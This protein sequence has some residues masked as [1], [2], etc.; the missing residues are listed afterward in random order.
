MAIDLVN[1]H[2]RRRREK[3]D[4][5]RQGMVLMHQ[6]II[7]TKPLVASCELA[8]TDRAFQDLAR[9]AVGLFKAV[10]AMEAGK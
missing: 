8:G 9:G 3:A 10:M 2:V 5:M 6:G 1:G 7:V 4:A